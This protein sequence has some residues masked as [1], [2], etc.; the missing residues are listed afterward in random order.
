MEECRNGGGLD[1]LPWMGYK[2]SSGNG[3]AWLSGERDGRDG[4]LEINFS[5]QYFFERKSLWR[6]DVSSL[7]SSSSSFLRHEERV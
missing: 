2:I 4:N 5:N 3:V 6:G 7:F 1:F